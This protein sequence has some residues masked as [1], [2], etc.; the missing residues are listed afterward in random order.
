MPRPPFP[1]MSPYDIPLFASFVISPKGRTYNRWEFDVRVGPPTDIGP[2]FGEEARADALALSR[3]RIDAVG[4]D[5]TGPT[6]FEVKPDARL[7]AFGQIMAYKFFYCRDVGSSCKAAIIT[8]SC[9]PY[10]A[11]LYP[12][13]DIGLHLVRP[14]S[15]DELLA[16]IQITHPGSP[17]RWADIKYLYEEVDPTD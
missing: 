15:P 1:H 9:R 5:G 6:L 11:L 12:A 7:S 17:L 14:A 16:A 10:C 3:V 8:D 2:T 13:H 4:W